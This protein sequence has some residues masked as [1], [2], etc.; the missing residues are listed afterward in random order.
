M[1]LD[2]ARSGGPVLRVENL[3]VRYGALQAL[4]DVSWD[5]GAGEILGIIGPNGAGKSTCYDAVTN[6]VTREGRVVL[7]GEDVTDVP[8][9]DLA[10]RGLRRAFQQN[11]FFDHLTVLENMIAVIQDEWGT[12]FGG[13]IFRPQAERRRA[14]SARDAAAEK[15]VRMHVPREFHDR[16]PSEIPYG[17]QR[18]LSIALAHG[19]GAKVLMLDEP[20]AGLGGDDMA[21]L[22]ELLEELRRDGISVVVIEHHMDL[23]MSVADHIV[24]LD[25]GRMLAHG[26]PADIQENEAVLDAYLG[27]DA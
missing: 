23:I 3:G 2:M 13:C 8:P 20:A 5:V 19:S 22:V 16:Y 1:A 15:L 4:A 17:T 9:H 6:L 11:A 7:G 21:A 25:Q 12:S 27:R 24:V 18:M 26:R 14:A 10:G